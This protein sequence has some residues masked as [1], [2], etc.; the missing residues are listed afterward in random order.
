MFTNGSFHVGT[1]VGGFSLLTPPLRSGAAPFSPPSSAL[2]TSDPSKSLTVTQLLVRKS[3]SVE[4]CAILYSLGVRHSR[5]ECRKSELGKVYSQ[6]SNDLGLVAC[7]GTAV[8]DNASLQSCK[9]RRG[10]YQPCGSDDLPTTICKETPTVPHL[11][12][13]QATPSTELLYLLT[14]PTSPR[15]IL[16]LLQPRPTRLFFHPFTV[17]HT[18]SDNHL[19]SSTIAAYRLSYSICC[20]TLPPL[21]AYLRSYVMA[22]HCLWDRRQQELRAPRGSTFPHAIVQVRPRRGSTPCPP[23][24]NANSQAPCTQ[25]TTSNILTIVRALGG[26]YNLHLYG[27]AMAQWLYRSPPK[28][29]QAQSPTGSLQMFAS[30]NR[31]GRCRWSADFLGDLPFRPTLHS[32]DAPFPP[33]FTFIGSQDLSVDSRPNILLLR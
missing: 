12:K 17:W 6:R 16:S 5:M 19:P 14:R 4:A 30:G 2:K 18:A 15:S 32:G 20:R 10:V 31:A 29:N 3:L 11:W 21:T 27:A 23:W 28:A 13:H 7:H 26:S 8:K 1:L 9:P 33:H 25:S 24:C 22:E